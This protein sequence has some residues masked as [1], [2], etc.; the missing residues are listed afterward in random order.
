MTNEQQFFLNILSDHLN[1]RVSHLSPSI[2]WPTLF[3]ISD[4]HQM[5]DIVF[6]QCKRYIED[7][8]NLQE[9]RQWLV[10][11]QASHLFQMTNRTRSFQNLEKKLTELNIPFF[12]FKGAEIARYY[13]VPSL[14]MSGDIDF[15]MHMDDRDRVHELLINSGYTAD[16]FENHEW[17]YKSKN[18]YF[19]IHDRLLFEENYN[20][21]EGI[22]F[23]DRCWDYV[24][25]NPGTSR[26]TLDLSFHF[27][28]LILHLRKHMLYE[29]VGFR[30][31]Y[32]LAVL[33]K[34]AEEQL[35][36][37][38]ICTE[39]TN[40]HLL[41]FAQTCMTFCKRWFNVSCPLAVG[42]FSEEFYEAATQK[43]FA[44]GVF[45]FGDDENK[46]NA[47]LN[48]LRDSGK[49][50]TIVS[51]IFPSYKIIRNVPYYSFVKGKP[52]LLPVVWLYRLFR[53]LIYGKGADGVKL[54]NSAV[55][56]DKALA[57]RETVL[58]QWG[59]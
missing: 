26:K 18:A 25:D 45:G 50:K 42:Q 15:M 19:E 52:W 48:A 31:F 37:V 51:R 12:P 36:W 13:P 1:G 28:Y 59:L 11:N 58:R 38:W 22:A 5:T 10:T 24:T 20:T 23:C 9:V 47:N 14:R 54:I 17:I 55:T 29:G 6:R 21:S 39:L 8:P 40:I 33:A 41:Q 35:D 53:S 57:E 44:N 3:Q 7:N 46:E 30:Q 27:V 43:I 16:T 34:R 4:S 49:I 56:V 32:D 2:I